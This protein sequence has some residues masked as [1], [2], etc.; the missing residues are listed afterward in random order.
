[1]LTNWNRPRI[2]LAEG[3]TEATSIPAAALRLSEL[4]S[5]KYT[6][7]EA[8]GICTVDAG[9]DGS[10]VDLAKLYAG[11]GKRVFAVCDKQT[12]QDEQAIADEVED[13]FMH[14][15]SAIEKLVLKESSEEAL[16]RFS[17]LLDWPP[18]ITDKYDIDGDFKRA[19]KAYFKWSK[20]N[21]GVSDFL[22]QCDEDEMPQW[23]RDTCESLK[24][25]F[26][27]DDSGDDT[28]EL[29]D[30]PSDDEAE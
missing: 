24:H 9:G 4:N 23:I 30:G 16:K 2:L 20:G 17:D 6:S 3:A 7:L 1:M 18:H 19:L 8:L 5:S 21:W 27:D 10:I 12:D 29:E 14:S 25:K 28:D 11:L 15:E 22:A 26:H 13:Y